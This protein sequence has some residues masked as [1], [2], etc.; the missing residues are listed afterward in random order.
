LNHYILLFIIYSDDTVIR[1]TKWVIQFI[2]WSTIGLHTTILLTPWYPLFRWYSKINKMSD[3]IY[4]KPWLKNYWY[5]HHHFMEPVYQLLWPSSILYS[6]SINSIFW[7]MFLM[8][9]TENGMLIICIV[10]TRLSSQFGKQG[11]WTSNTFSSSP[12][13]CA[14]YAAEKASEAA[15]LF[16]RLHLPVEGGLICICAVE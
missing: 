5:A 14:M 12:I 13:G 2:G 4:G 1:L 6:C 10:H 16:C 3:S 9:L 7:S 11:Q 8:C 15:W